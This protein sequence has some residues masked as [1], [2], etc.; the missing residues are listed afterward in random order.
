[1][2]AFYAPKQRILSILAV[3]RL[4]GATETI[5][6]HPNLLVYRQS[7]PPVRLTGDVYVVDKNEKVFL[8]KHVFSNTVP[9][10][11]LIRG[12]YES[13]SE[14]KSLRDLNPWV[15]NTLLKLLIPDS[16]Q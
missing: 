9:A 2:N 14:L 6:F 10:Y 5:D 1:M 11:L 7:S 8:V 16:V 4:F 13:S 12:D 3:N 15:Q